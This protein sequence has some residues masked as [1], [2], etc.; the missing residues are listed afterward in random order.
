MPGAEHLRYRFVVMIAEGAGR[1][2]HD[3]EKTWQLPPIW[4]RR[5]SI[6]EKDGIANERGVEM[7][8]DE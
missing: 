8:V 7:V 4:W 1:Y 6:R 3:A 5:L 2:I